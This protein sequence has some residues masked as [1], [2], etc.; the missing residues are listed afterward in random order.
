VRVVP[1]GI[2]HRVASPPDEGAP[3]PVPLPDGTTRYVLA[4][5]TIEPRKDLPGL[6]RAFDRVAGDHPDVA[7]VLAGSSG[8]G[9]DALAGA[10]DGA[11]W[12]SRIV[13]PGY[14][15]DADLA[16][17]LAG[18]AVLAYPSVYEGFGFPPLE[19]MRAGV[20]VVTTMAGSIP[21]V[22]GDGAV[23]TPVGDTDALAAA[24]ASLLDDPT[25]RREL[26]TRGRARAAVFTW[27][28]CAD[29]LASL[30]ADAA[31]AR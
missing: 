9:G 15:D 13:R 18:A 28:A 30:Y 12:R 20:P 10:V 2:P 27:T 11:R 31:V 19:A 4:V 29:G 24:L 21:E 6:V 3:P 26:I 7:L 25:A 16:T 23:L 1:L 5:G 17:V 8:W 22:V 14:L